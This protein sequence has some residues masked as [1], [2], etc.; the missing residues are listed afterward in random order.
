MERMSESDLVNEIINWFEKIWIAQTGRAWQTPQIRFTFISDTKCEFS[1]R[2]GDGKIIELMGV[3]N[4]D[5]TELNM[6][7][8]NGACLAVAPNS[9]RLAKRLNF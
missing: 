2:Q 9:V 3:I 5:Q 1:I 4:S 6:A 7:Y 8:S